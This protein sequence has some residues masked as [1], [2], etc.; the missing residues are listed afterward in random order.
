MTRESIL[1]L[2]GGF[3]CARGVAFSTRDCRR[4]SR[5]GGAPLITFLAPTLKMNLGNDDDDDDD[6]DD[7]IAAFAVTSSMKLV[8]LL[9]EDSDADDEIGRTL[10][11]GL[12]LDLRDGSSITTKP[13]VASGVTGLVKI[14]SAI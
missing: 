6:D 4:L 13:G 14:V 3:S 9:N 1:G 10:I 7:A 5:D 11:I 8:A 12:S 2:E